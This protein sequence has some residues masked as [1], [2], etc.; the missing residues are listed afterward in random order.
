MVLEVGPQRVAELTGGLLDPLGPTVLDTLRVWLAHGQDVPATA[1]A[2][3]VH[4]N[5]VRNRLGRVT[6][7]VGDLRD[8]SVLAGIY[9]ALLTG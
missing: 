4:Q 9:L 6:A 2:L 5:S 3:Q 1:R 8:P 7:L